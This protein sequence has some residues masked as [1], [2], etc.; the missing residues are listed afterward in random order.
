MY[1]EPRLFSLPPPTPRLF[2]SLTLGCLTQI[3]N[4]KIELALLNPKGT[5]H[6]T[7]TTAAPTI[8]VVGEPWHSRGLEFL[9]IPLSLTCHGQLVRRSRASLLKSTRTDHYAPTS[10]QAA[11]LCLMA[12]VVSSWVSVLSQCPLCGCRLYPQCPLVCAQCSRG[13]FPLKPLCRH[14]THTSYKS[15]T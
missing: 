15:P 13:D 9:L 2:A 12:A 3:L 1:F 5:H 10:G 7:P 8:S 14:I 6:L 4:S 11:F